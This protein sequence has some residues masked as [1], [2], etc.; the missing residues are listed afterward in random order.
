MRPRLRAVQPGFCAGFTAKGAPCKRRV[1]SGPYCVHHK[2]PTFERWNRELSAELYLRHLKRHPYLQDNLR[3][4]GLST[5]H[6]NPPVLPPPPNADL[7]NARPN[8]LEEF[9]YGILSAIAVL[10]ARVFYGLAI[11]ALA[12]VP[13]LAVGAIGIFVMVFIGAGVAML[14]MAAY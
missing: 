3:R 7:T 14:K 6:L 4:A 10:A 2:E 5:L 11:V 8:V 13:M 1:K 9:V 12:F